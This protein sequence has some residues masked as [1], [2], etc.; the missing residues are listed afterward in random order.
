MKRTGGPYIL[1]FVSP[2]AHQTGRQALL[3][4]LQPAASFRH[5]QSLLKDL[6]SYL[7]TSDRAP[8]THF[9]R[10]ST[11]AM[12]SASAPNSCPIGLEAVILSN[13]FTEKQSSG[14]PKKSALLAS[15]LNLKALL[16]LFQQLS[17]LLFLLRLRDDDC[18]LLFAGWWGPVALIPYGMLQPKWPTCIVWHRS[19]MS[20]FYGDTYGDTYFHSTLQFYHRV[21]WIWRRIRII[22]V[23][24]TTRHVRQLVVLGFMT[25]MFWNWYNLHKSTKTDFAYYGFWKWYAKTVFVETL[26]RQ[27]NFRR[28]PRKSP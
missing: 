28:L 1:Q 16:S 6:L 14:L 2:A 10:R 22:S 27:S 26:V 25:T 17:L 7:L 20:E 11:W 15:I 3:S 21:V 9:H 23:A 12:S 24:R 4:P 5:F 18:F 19:I 8:L 13:H